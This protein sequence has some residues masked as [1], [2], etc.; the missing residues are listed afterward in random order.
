[1]KSSPAALMRGNSWRCSSPN[2]RA[3]NIEMT[4]RG[5]GAGM[6]GVLFHEL[7]GS[8]E[9]TTGDAL[10]DLELWMARV[11]HPPD[12]VRP[13]HLAD[14]DRRHVG[15]AGVHP[16]AHPLGQVEPHGSRLPD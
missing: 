10:A 14:L 3:E 8:R 9:A 6:G 11:D 12:P 2:G 13:H 16:P 15:A 5:E 7:L 4:P 1:M